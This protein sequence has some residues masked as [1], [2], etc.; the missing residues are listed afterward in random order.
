[1]KFPKGLIFLIGVIMT[2]TVFASGH[3]NAGLITGGLGFGGAWTPRDA[4]GNQVSIDNA[5]WVD[6]DAAAVT[7]KSLS[8]PIRN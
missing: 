1:M 2:L 3:A 6:I 7:S 5:I 8:P 4:V